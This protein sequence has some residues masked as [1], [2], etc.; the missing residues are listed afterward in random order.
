MFSNKIAGIIG[1]AAI[2]V[3]ILV[4]IAWVLDIQEIKSIIPNAAPMRFT[5]GL[6]FIVSGTLLYSLTTKSGRM[7]SLAQITVPISV[8]IILLVST[9]VLVG[10]TVGLN[11]GIE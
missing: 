1:F 8:F 10:Y 9:T 11:T 2:I 4:C 3:G 6:L 5:T 7:A